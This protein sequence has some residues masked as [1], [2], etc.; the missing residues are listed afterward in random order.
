LSN[1]DRPGT[2][3]Q[4]PRIRAFCAEHPDL[5]H[6]EVEQACQI[7]DAMKTIARVNPKFAVINGGDG[8][9]SGGFDRALQRRPFQHRRAAAGG[10]AAPSGKTNLIAMD[11]ASRRSGGRLERLLA[12]RPV[13]PKSAPCRARTDR[14]SLRRRDRSR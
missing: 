1:R 10:G 6:Y 11:L 13:R 5:F 2:I 4:L 9:V 12:D 14:A 3:A 7:G 8:T